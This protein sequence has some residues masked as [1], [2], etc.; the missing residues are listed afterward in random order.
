M[1]GTDARLIE[2]RDRLTGRVLKGSS[3]VQYYLRELIGEGGQGWVF[4]A[5]WDEP[6]GFVVIVK[7]LRPDAVSG[8]AL[9]RFQREAEV[10]RLLSQQARPIP[11]IVRFFDHAIANMPSPIGGEPLVLPFTVLEYVNGSTLE[12]VLAE[13]PG[14]GMPLD[15]ARR[16]LKHV[17]QALEAVHAQ[18]VVHRDLKPSNILLAKE[19]GI[20]V[21]KVTDFGLV[22]LVDPN[23]RSTVTL[24]GASIG[25]APPE[26]Y[27]KGNKRVSAQTDVFSFAAIAFE[28]I[29]GRMAFPF[30]DGDNPLI[31]I[32]RI[33]GGE[34]PSLRN[35][36]KAKLSP[37]LEGRAGLIERIDAE[38]VQAL[39]AS[40]DK[41][42][43]SVSDLWSALEPLFRGAIDGSMVGP[44][45][46]LKAVSAQ[47]LAF[48]E[49]MPAYSSPAPSAGANAAAHLGA[50]RPSVANSAPVPAAGRPA[51]ASGAP[52]AVIVSAEE[53]VRKSAPPVEGNVSSR[54]QPAAGVI[55]SMVRVRKT[56]AEA[57]NPAA[58]QWRIITPSL[59][60][61]VVRAASF[62]SDGQSGVGVGPGG[63]AR[64]DRSTWVG[65]SLPTGL[66]PALARGVRKLRSGDVVLFGDSSLLARIAPS[67]VHELIGSP[68]RQAS[69]HGAHVDEITGALL[70]VGERPLQGRGVRPGATVGT[71]LAVFDS[72]PGAL[73]DILGS[74]R[75]N[76]VSR[77]LSG[78][79]IACG[80]WGA[81]GRFEG[82]SQARTADTGAGR[83]LGSICS[84]HLHAIAAMPDG[85]AVTVGAGGYAL[86][87]T[88]RLE[89][90]LEAVQTTKDLACVTVG[91]DGTPWAGAGQARVL[92]REGGAWMRM[93]GE[94]G[95]ASNVLAIWASDR[96]VRAMCDDGAVLEGQ[97]T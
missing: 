40:P 89:P 27:E 79:L 70:F 4:R 97:L 33:L 25:Y 15:R 76:A 66:N 37:E 68:D 45:I 14:R 32:S 57:A 64:W 6:D 28:L 59:S 53:A 8:D 71:A 56:D 1:Q 41:R 81:L 10:L 85:G 86:Y 35:I 78:A 83:F 7:V 90:K 73:V 63:V 38:M 91:A 75:L 95:L 26:Q 87:L 65:V 12:T 2:L 55:D 84:G 82:D 47:D 44:S 94:L 30:R 13:T 50:T 61:G 46:E 58:W 3:G 60:P 54:V 43:R 62:A 34:R 23:L 19:A 93:T 52:S 9:S 88:P 20:E 39:D 48:T 21:A 11:Y 24:A 29:S 77:I 42:H 18:K 96:S 31:V 16:I 80:D 49:T 5:N 69:F 17:A 67:G 36:G 74:T 72:R 92:R 51:V 22:K